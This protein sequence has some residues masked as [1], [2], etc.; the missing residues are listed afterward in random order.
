MSMSH[1]SG[2]AEMH[3]LFK[4]QA[5]CTILSKVETLDVRSEAVVKGLSTGPVSMAYLCFT[6]ESTL[7]TCL[8]TLIVSGEESA[9]GEPSEPSYAAPW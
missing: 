5:T 6:M 4:A 1:S 2:A 7:S 3:R 9:G 8:C